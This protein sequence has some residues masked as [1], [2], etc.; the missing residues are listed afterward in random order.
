MTGAG[1]ETLASSKFTPCPIC[2]LKVNAQKLDRHK[3]RNHPLEATPEERAARKARDE[4]SAKRR[5]EQRR[6]ERERREADRRRSAPYVEE[7]PSDMF[8]S[9]YE[10]PRTGEIRPLLMMD[11]G[12]RPVDGSGW[13]A[14][15]DED[16]GWDGQEGEPTAGFEEEVLVQL[17][18]SWAWEGVPALKRRYQPA[19]VD[20][21]RGAK[22]DAHAKRLRAAEV[23]ARDARSRAAE[24][25]GRLAWCAE[26]VRDA[27]DRTLWHGGSLDA[28][29]EACLVQTFLTVAGI[30][31]DPMWDPEAP[32]EPSVRDGTAE[33]L[34]LFAREFGSAITDREPPQGGAYSA[35]L[36]VKETLEGAA[37][38]ASSL[39]FGGLLERA[40]AWARGPAPAPTEEGVRRLLAKSPGD[41]AAACALGRLLAAGGHV[42]QAADELRLFAGLSLAPH[43]IDLQVVLLLA[44]AGLEEN[45]RERAREA[46]DLR[47]MG[48]QPSEE[49]LA[50]RLN[51]RLVLALLEQG[52]GR[53]PHVPPRA[54][55]AALELTAADDNT[56]FEGSERGDDLDRRRGA[57]REPWDLLARDPAAA[58][59]ALND[60]VRLV[61]SWS[62]GLAIPLLGK[63][64]DP[65][66]SVALAWASRGESASAEAAAAALREIGPAAAPDVA[67][68][69]GGLEDARG[70]VGL[71]EIHLLSAL[72]ELGG[73]EAV[74]E[75]VGFLRRG[76][77][78]GRVVQV[79][80][81][82]FALTGVPDEGLI[83]DIARG[84]RGERD[85]LDLRHAVKRLRRHRPKWP[86]DGATCGFCGSAQSVAVLDR[87]K[88]RAV[89]Q[90]C[91]CEGD[92]R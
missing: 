16:G 10:D 85:F 61:D 11:E 36:L 13:T 42:E 70:G 14:G 58:V 92:P 19:W 59:P 49:E 60:L 74:D 9:R 1:G 27:P 50:C 79:E 31:S 51:L 82:A 55:A 78:N 20:A 87:G 71:D 45:A 32:F 81:A 24:T 83:A 26:A 68:V 17:L 69:L 12:G 4:A 37:E 80:V 72:A 57:V 53:V 43:E 62:G 65:S 88:G 23:A 28:R 47:D 52:T 89:C 34:K 63:A 8:L 48:T 30:H 44:D 35:L 56:R 21:R 54:V 2:G 64:R 22:L 39:D 38:E 90:R 25:Y 77:E 46:L 67:A 76:E 33:E 40:E 66:A 18:P 75:V 84:V 3:E 41:P 5:A 91:W 15:G 7:V 73:R 6:E 29:R 86:V